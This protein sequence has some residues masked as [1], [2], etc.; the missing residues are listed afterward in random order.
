M[1]ELIVAMAVFAVLAS[2]AIYFLS[3]TVWSAETAARRAQAAGYMQEGVEAVQA[4]DHTAWN[5]LADTPDNLYGLSNANG[6]WEFINDPDN[7]D[8]NTDYTR[9]V[10]VTDVFRNVAGDIVASDASTAVLD[11]HTRDVNVAIEWENGPVTSDMDATVYVTDWDATFQADTTNIDF[12]AGTLANAR[13]STIDD[14]EVQILQPT[15]EIGSVT[16][17]SVWTTVQ[18]DNTYTDPVVVTAVVDGANPNSPV[19]ARVQ[20]RTSTSFDLRL[21]FPPDNFA[22]SSTNAETVNYLVIEAGTW[23]LGENQTKIE[24]GV[25]QDVSALDCS[26]CGWLNGP[27][28]NY[29]LTYDT[30]P[31]VFHQIESE[32]DSS[33]VQSIV[34]AHNAASNPPTTIGFQIAMNG[35]Q[36]TTTHAAEDIGYVVIERDIQDV[37]EGLNFET[38]ATEDAVTGYTDTP[39]FTAPFVQTYISTPWTLA[40]QMT[41]DGGDGAWAMID[42]VTSADMTVYVDEDQT[43]DSERS[44]TTEDVALLAFAYPGTYYLDAA[45]LFFN[46]PTMEV[47]VIDPETVV[48]NGNME[49][50][51]VIADTNWSTVSLTETYVDPVV[52]ASIVGANNPSSP[53]SARVRN[54]GAN[55]FELR[56]DFPPDNFPPNSTNAETVNYIVMESGLWEIG[57]SGVHVEAGVLPSVTALNC[58][59]GCSWNTGVNVNFEQPYSAPPAVF[60]Q[61]MSE[62]DSSWITSFTASQSSYSTPPTTTGFRL[63]MNGSEVTNSHGAED[64]GY[65]AIATEQTDLIDGTLFETDTTGDTVFGMNSPFTDTFDQTYSAP[66]WTLVT[67]MTMDGGNGGWSMMNNVNASTITMYAQED[68][69]SDAETDHT[70]EDFGYMAFGQIGSFPI[71]GSTIITDPITVQ[72]Q[73]TYSNPVV[74]TLPYLSLDTSS[75]VSTRVYNVTSDSFDLR[76]DF[77]P[78][79]FPPVDTAFREPVHYMVMEAGQWQIGD[80]KIEA[81]VETV[82]TVG[83]IAGWSSDIYEYDHNFDNPPIVLHQVMSDDDPSWITTWARGTSS[84]ANPPGTQDF[85]MALQAAEVISSQGHGPETVGWV[86]IED[87]GTDTHEGLPFQTIIGNEAVFGHADGCY[88]TTYGG[89][90]TDPI[91]IASQTTMDGGNGGWLSMCALTDTEVGFHVE[92]DQFTD[93]E[94]THTDE[95]YTAIMFSEPFSSAGGAP[96]VPTI[97]G[98][99]ESRIFG[100]GSTERNFNTIEWNENID[101]VACNVQI[102]V[103]SATNLVDLA[104][105]PYIGPDGTSATSYEAPTGDLLPLSSIGDTYV[106]YLATLVGTLSG[107][108]QLT[109]VEVFQY[110]N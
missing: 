63:A 6:Q 39:H 53:V 75:P 30:D 51:T 98:T 79:N 103:R 14:G 84:A 70:D 33:W 32:N 1:V 25:V 9:T 101:C 67:Q 49:I 21:D 68:Q 29:E 12:T 24:A 60:H 59:L 92:E 19:S 96:N 46:Y 55:S 50:G 10:T 72:L 43:G 74:I 102:Q 99:I 71:T 3:A 38:I 76:Y 89:P 61:I 85:R 108:P 97:S 15:L 8:N 28:I 56:L 4:L 93:A 2:G 82:S 16:A 18:L 47:G 13:V 90:Y 52:V 58:A 87:V 80:T 20:S 65:I 110:E 34:T 45:D 27:V 78:D 83:S 95:D 106:Q 41:I 22:P 73:Q 44:H 7:P 35:T 48:T 105:A 86:A 17:S 77:P 94:R 62:N 37:F 23:T 66:P 100:D 40:A 5:V 64:I 57:S 104:S 81:H 109:D 91:T 26:S 42:D 11:P 31:L 69:A 88:S 107:S 54:A 36:A